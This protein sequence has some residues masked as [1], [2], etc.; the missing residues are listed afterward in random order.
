LIQSGASNPRN[1]PKQQAR[2][3][4]HLGAPNSMTAAENSVDPASRGRE[5]T[6]VKEK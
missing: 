2:R 4:N 5:E 6:V 3:Y 1:T